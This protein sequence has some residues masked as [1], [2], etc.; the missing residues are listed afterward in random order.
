[1]NVPLTAPLCACQGLF[2]NYV[3]RFSLF[4]DN[5]HP[6]FL[7]YYHEN[8]SNLL[9]YRKVMLLK[10]QHDRTKIMTFLLIVNFWAKWFLITESLNYSNYCNNSSILFSESG[11]MQVFWFF[12]LNVKI[13]TNPFFL[14][15]SGGEEVG[16]VIHKWHWSK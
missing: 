11:T 15:L 12:V 2:I 3:T 9:A 16:G 1:M 14:M 8:W 4:L 6:Q 5:A 7:F 10:S 13:S